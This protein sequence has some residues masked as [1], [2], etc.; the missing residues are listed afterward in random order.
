VIQISKIARRC[1]IVVVIVSFNIL[2]PVS[3]DEDDSEAFSPVQ[4]TQMPG[5][6]ASNNVTSQKKT[7]DLHELPHE[8]RRQKRVE[9]EQLYFKHMTE[10]INQQQHGE[11]TIE[12][13][14]R[15]SRETFLE[16]Y[17]KPRKPAILTGMMD[18]WDATKSWDFDQLGMRRERNSVA[19]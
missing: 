17:M 7:A 19:A 1:C 3:V 13:V 9:R 10:Q 15:P 12:R 11:C 6:F 5:R 14:H 8:L 18:S 16:R 4:S 2:E